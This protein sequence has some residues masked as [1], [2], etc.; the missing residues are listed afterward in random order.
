MDVHLTLGTQRLLELAT[1]ST[2]DVIDADLTLCNSPSVE[3]DL[4]LELIRLIGGDNYRASSLD[5]RSAG[6]YL[7]RS[8]RSTARS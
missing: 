1:M 7:G 3:N 2:T 6:E 8:L 5:S 4:E